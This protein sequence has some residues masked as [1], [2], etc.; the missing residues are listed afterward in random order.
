MKKHI[1]ILFIIPLFLLSACVKKEPQSDKATSLYEQA[2]KKMQEQ[3]YTKAVDLFSEAIVANPKYSLAYG[4]RGA[5]KAQIFNNCKEAMPDLDMAIKLNSKFA[6]AYHNRGICKINLGKT[7]E[8]VKDFSKTLKINP[9]YFLSYN[10]RG[11]AYGMLGKNKKAIKDFDNTLKIKPNYVRAYIN[12]IH[13]EINM[14]EFDK[15]RADGEKAKQVLKRN[16][17]KDLSVMLDELLKQI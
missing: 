14:R 9:N 2:N 16:P 13:A 1:L 12:K 8:A 5:I 15:A 11:V 6:I 7:K 10:S 17:D 4:K 3:D